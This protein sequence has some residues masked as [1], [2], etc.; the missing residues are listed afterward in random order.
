MGRIKHS[1]GHKLENSTKLF[2]MVLR[3]DDKEIYIEKK[4]FTTLALFSYLGG[5]ATF[6]YKGF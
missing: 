5:F 3:L 1:Y 4:V 6:M 2:S